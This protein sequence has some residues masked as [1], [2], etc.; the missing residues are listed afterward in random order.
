M[1]MAEFIYKTMRDFAVQEG[2][3]PDEA[4][5]EAR[6]ALASL[7]DNPVLAQKIA[8]EIDSEDA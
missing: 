4:K 6:K 2:L 7:A 5:A 8:D 3:E 1:I